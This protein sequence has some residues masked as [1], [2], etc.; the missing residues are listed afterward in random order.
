MRL[1]KYIVKKIKLGT[2]FKQERNDMTTLRSSDQERPVTPGVGD[3]AEAIRR[4]YCLENHQVF[5]SVSDDY[6]YLQYDDRSG[7]MYL[8]FEESE[9]DAILLDND[10]VYFIKRIK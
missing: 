2:V 3:K 5:E 9:L 8:C 7:E 1:L 6:T 4:R 10:K